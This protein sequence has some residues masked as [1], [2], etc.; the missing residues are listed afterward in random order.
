MS[1]C[2]ISKV[3]DT[4][5]QVILSFCDKHPSH[6]R[7]LAEIWQVPG[8]LSKQAEQQS[9]SSYL[10]SYKGM[11]LTCRRFIFNARTSESMFLQKNYIE[12][13]EY[14]RYLHQLF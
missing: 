2:I 4:D 12:S 5:F 8:I 11:I 6:S 1:S 9:E 14:F 3:N 7:Y 13:E 10:I